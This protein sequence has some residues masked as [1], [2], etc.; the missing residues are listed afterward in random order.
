MKPGL[1]GVLVCASTVIV[2][3]SSAEDV[4]TGSV[5][6]E[7][8]DQKASYGIGRNVGRQIEPVC[9]VWLVVEQIYWSL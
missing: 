7:T 5:A 9:R 3:C 8:N 4:T 6:L 2:G 1:I